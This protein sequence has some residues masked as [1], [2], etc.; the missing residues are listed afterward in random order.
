MHANE[1]SSASGTVTLGM[2][3]AQKLRRNSKMTS[4]T[5]TMVRPA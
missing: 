3:V 5:S 1:P 2:N 4:T